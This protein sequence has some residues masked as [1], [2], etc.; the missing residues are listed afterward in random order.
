M[1]K[2]IFLGKLNKGRFAIKWAVSSVAY[3]ILIVPIVGVLSQSY[4]SLSTLLFWILTIFALI[5][6]ESLYVRRLRDLNKNVWIAAIGL[7]PFIEIILFVALYFDLNKFILSII[8]LI[9]IFF[10]SLPI[11]FFI[12]IR[13]DNKIDT[14]SLRLNKCYLLAKDGIYYYELSEFNIYKKLDADPGQFVTLDSELCYGKD[15]NN[16]YYRDK[17]LEGENPDTFVIPE[18]IY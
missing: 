3:L 1:I 18:E 17:V 15:G 2:N 10:A 5:Y 7:L 9:A 14:H 11:I 6:R 12:K 4:L 16:V 13:K 8:I